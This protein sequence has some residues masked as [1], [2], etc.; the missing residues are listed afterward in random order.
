VISWGKNFCYMENASDVEEMQ[1]F[2]PGKLN[3]YCIII[4]CDA[5]KVPLYEY[6]RHPCQINHREMSLPFGEVTVWVLKIVLFV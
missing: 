5:E 2:L 6:R 3:Y 1:L 4:I